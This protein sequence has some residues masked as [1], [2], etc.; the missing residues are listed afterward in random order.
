MAIDKKVKA[1][2]ASLSQLTKLKKTFDD[3]YE[4]F[5]T[6]ENY[7]WIITTEGLIRDVNKQL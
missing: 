3:L 7:G 5:P 1:L 6:N 4:L 2:N